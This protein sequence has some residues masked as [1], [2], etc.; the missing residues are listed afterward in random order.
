MGE[1]EFLSAELKK[2]LEEIEVA[3]GLRAGALEEEI[4]ARLRGVTE[5][6]V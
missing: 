3:R 6:S 5:P 1:G 4:E 2:L